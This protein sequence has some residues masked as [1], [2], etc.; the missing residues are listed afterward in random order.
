MDKK[1][2][3]GLATASALPLFLYIILNLMFDDTVCLI[4]GLILWLLITALISNI[5]LKFLFNLRKLNAVIE[6]ISNGDYT[7]DSKI[8]MVKTDPFLAKVNQGIDK[9]IAGI[10]SMMSNI[11]TSS[12][13]TYVST[14]VLKD[15]I[16]SLNA[17][18]KEIVEAINQIAAS[19]EKQT[20]GI[21][22][23]N[24]QM[25]ILVN[26]AQNIEKK[27][28]STSDRIKR[29]QTV[30]LEMQHT[31]DNVNT[32]IEES[33]DSTQQSYEAYTTLGREADKIGS[34][35]RA[36]SEIATQT[37]LL[38]LNAAIEAARAGEHGKGFAVVAE[39]VRKLAE[40]SSNSAGEI[41]SIISVILNEMKRLA[42]LSEKNLQNIQADVREV[43]VAKGQ[44]KN[45]VDEF[46]LMKDYIG[47]IE[48][49]SVN[50]SK[51]ATV[52]EDALRDISAIAEQNMTQAEESA[53]MTMEQSNLSSEIE[54]A[55]QQ[56]VNISQEIRK[57][58]TK[59]A[60]GEDGIN[61]KMKA[62]INSGM[63]QLSRLAEQEAIRNIER[64]K[65]KYLIDKA[66][67]EILDVIHF[68]DTQG[69]VIY[70]TSSSNS[71]R[72]H[73]AWFLHGLK[74]EYCTDPYFSAVSTENN[75]VVTIALP[76]YNNGKVR[77]VLAANIVKNV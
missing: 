64:D 56:L 2:I 75:S 5:S 40:Q 44:L 32:G 3:L 41:E 47:E 16:E 69:N 65:C 23:I 57:L 38:A 28:L 15:N 76:V 61:E 63:S 71:S 22:L 43:Q 33:A 34:I 9:V 30:I 55:S 25:E 59:F 37:N 51:N 18:N 13:K 4:A 67:N 58:S 72:A 66:K 19:A 42:D 26:S 62:K 31:F 20:Q 46:S 45:I 10:R 27:A 21:M 53:A 68:I 24:E 36:V 14:Y 29:L 11:L 39:E 1:I 70:T 73:R 17:S 48:L 12:E 74:G 52:V 50:Q 7:V 54:K 35:V 49:L 8:L 60:Q 6:K 77:A